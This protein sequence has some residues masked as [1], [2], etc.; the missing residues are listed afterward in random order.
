MRLAGSLA[1]VLLAGGAQAATPEGHWAMLDQYCVKCHNTTDW[2]GE[3]ALDTMDHTDSAV[4]ADAETWEKVIVRMRGRL[5]P[6]PGEKRPANAEMDSF[7]HWMEGR[8]DANAA[9]KPQ[10]GYVPLH[11]LNRR[12]YAYAIRDLF[13]LTFDPSALLPQDDL[14][15]GFDTT[16]KVLQVSPTF[17]DQYLAAARSVAVQAVGNPGQRMVGTP[18]TNPVPGPQHNHV[19]GLPCGTRGGFAVDHIFPA[20]GEYE[21]NISTVARALWVEGMEFENRL[22][23]LV[24]GV[25]VYETSL[26]G[27]ADQKAIDQKGDA[28]V[29]AINAR[30]KNIRFHAKAGQHHVAVTFRARS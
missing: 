23:A 12:E 7:V 8:I 6:P 1:G 17:L 11:R 15:D 26:G 21:L 30:L 5:M 14:S 19:E 22:V 25:V 24:E 4:A 9:G 20:D 18:Y 13:G 29:D 16:A 28:P 27:G 2:A 3:M 10:A